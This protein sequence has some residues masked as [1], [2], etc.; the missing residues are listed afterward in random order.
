MVKFWH[1]KYLDVVNIREACTIVAL[2]TGASW[3]IF[4]FFATNQLDKAALEVK[5][6]HHSLVP[7]INVKIQ[8]K[9][10]R[11]NQVGDTILTEVT[12]TNQGKF[13]EILDL[14]KS[15]FRVYPVKFPEKTAEDAAM[16]APIAMDDLDQRGQL[17]I[18]N[19]A[20]WHLS[21]PVFPRAITELELKPGEQEHLSWLYRPPEPFVY[22]VEFRVPL[23]ES[24]RESWLE[25]GFDLDDL[26][27]V[28]GVFLEVK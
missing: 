6:L 15:R 14:S 25:A 28:D 1:K 19:V 7:V 24:S 22:Y 23:S 9:H 26:N 2:I 10:W 16:P 12:L 17:P 18:P 13:T 5:Q 27:W 4:T 3:A 11:T 20:P 8:A 21:A